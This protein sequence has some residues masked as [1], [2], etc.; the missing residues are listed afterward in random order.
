MRRLAARCEVGAMT[1]YG[2]VRTKEELLSALA[3]RFMS[4]IELP[5]GEERPW[6]EQI[7]SVFR[8]VRLVF[9]KH[10]ELLPIA[11]SQRLEGA[12]V[13][14]G[15]ELVFAALRR[16]GLD[17]RQV[18]VAFDA[19]T[20]FTVGAAQREAGLGAH[21]AETLPGIR[22]LPPESFAN[23]IGLAG[24]LITRDPA[25]SFDAGL[26]LLLAGIASWARAKP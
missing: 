10:P 24:L 20:S 15:A 26:E 8:S 18:V 23:V 3:N 5:G 7:A 6:D 1:R 13:Y 2:Y 12:G 4:E 25:Q 21:D 19:L 14:R 11:A 9:L 22:E 16:A 17:D